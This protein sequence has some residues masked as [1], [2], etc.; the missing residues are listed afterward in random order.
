MWF[1]LALGSALFAGLHTFSIKIAVERKFDT[2]LLSTISSFV[3]FGAGL[4]VLFFT[5]GWPI[6]P[7]IWA[8]GILGGVLF[9]A[10]SITRMEG[11]K[12]LDSAIFFPLYKV[13]GP[14]LVATIGILLVHEKVAPLEVLGIILSCM[15]PLLLITKG[16]HVRQKNLKLGL[17]LMLISTTVSALSSV[18]N[19]LVV[20]GIPSYALPLALLANGFTGLFS[21][22]LFAR[23]HP[24]GEAYHQARQRLSS[25]FWWLAIANG[26]VQITSSWML[27]LAFAGG[28]MSLVYSVTAHYILIPVLLSVWIYKEHWNRQKAAALVISILALIFLHR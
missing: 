11:M 16:E 18:V 8:F 24:S 27:F 2:Y 12:F 23:R 19:A 13:I 22:I 7:H 17:L 26:V 28:D 9:T 20:D 25:G 4:V 10:F 21:L 1:A 3:S 5:G 6:P 15:V 14:A